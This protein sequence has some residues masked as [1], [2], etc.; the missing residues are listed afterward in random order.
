[1]MKAQMKNTGIDSLILKL[2]CRWR[3]VAASRC[4]RFTP[5][6][7]SRCPLN[8]KQAGLQSRS[9]RFGGE[10]RLLLLNPELNR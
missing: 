1:M 8:R 9:E 2:G 6:E 7:E 10:K 3:R 5:R 4:G